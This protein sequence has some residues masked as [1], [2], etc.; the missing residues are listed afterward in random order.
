M[1]NDRSSHDPSCRERLN[2][3]LERLMQKTVVPFLGAGVS[4]GAR[5]RRDPGFQPTT[6]YMIRKLLHKLVEEGRKVTPLEAREQLSALLRGA[7]TGG[8]SDERLNHLLD[9]AYAIEDLVEALV[10]SVSLDRAAEVLRWLTCQHNVCEASRIEVFHCLEPLEAHRYLAYLAR[11]GLI[12]EI[13]TTNYDCCLEKAYWRSFAAWNVAIED[14]GTSDEELEARCPTLQVVRDLEEY[15]EK[16]GRQ[17]EAG[18]PVLH[19][20]KI[21]GCSRRYAQRRLTPSQRHKEEA[22]EQIILT[23]R[24]LQDFRD[25]Y[26]ARDLFRDRARSRTLVFNGFGSEEPQIRHTVLALIQEF[27][28]QQSNRGSINPQQVWKLANAPFVVTY[29]SCPSYSQSQIL[30]SYLAAHSGS[31]G[32]GLER[33]W[34]GNLFTGRD[35]A[36]FESG[37]EARGSDPSRKLPADLFWKRIFQAAY[38]KLLARACQR[39]SPFYSWLSEHIEAA[40]GIAGELYSWLYPD[41]Q[42]PFGRFPAW[43]EPDDRGRDGGPPWPLRLSSWLLCMQ[44]ETKQ[45]WLTREQGL[46]LQETR[47]PYTQGETKQAWL[48]PYVPLREQPLLIPCL[49]LLLWLCGGKEASP[50]DVVQET[51]YGLRVRSLRDGGESVRLFLITGEHRTPAMI[52]SKDSAERDRGA[53]LF[54]IG[55]PSLGSLRDEERLMWKEGSGQT[56]VQILYPA[57]IRRMPADALVQDLVQ[58]RRTLRAAVA[59]W[60]SPRRR[61]RLVLVGVPK[62]HP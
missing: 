43:L 2:R 21:N 48:T 11:E 5:V 9:P 57:R 16:A 51:P 36:F 14:L 15:R 39:G 19:I 60:R 37:S 32:G 40:A 45:A 58:K 38:G 62:E 46:E 49:L 20:Y 10:P 3:L 50:V 17:E 55:V 61:V 7:L 1:T 4:V 18:R 35:L 42:K 47:D 23:E 27:D 53:L 26:W 24:Q 52:L 30:Q 29:D 8:Q 41:D 22:A 34:S 33:L 54:Q 44:G 13:I 12:T 25:A 28:W 6:D 56:A 59:A 31:I